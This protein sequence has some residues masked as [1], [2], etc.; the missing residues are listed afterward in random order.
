MRISMGPYCH[1]VLEFVR[2]QMFFFC[3]MDYTF[4]NRLSYSVVCIYI[5]REKIRVE[6]LLGLANVRFFCSIYAAL[7]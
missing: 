2:I 5:E 4:V 1:I 6:F 3:Q 7:V